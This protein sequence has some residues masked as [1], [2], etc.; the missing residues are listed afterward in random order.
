MEMN[1]VKQIISSPKEITVTYHGE[2]VWLKD[3]NE[4]D[5]SVKVVPNADSDDEMVLPADE[6]MEEH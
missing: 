6:L 3:Y 2:P 4:N 1:R 5:N